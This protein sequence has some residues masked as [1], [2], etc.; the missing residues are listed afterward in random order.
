[1]FKS[2]TYTYTSIV[3]ISGVKWGL[4]QAMLLSYKP[5]GLT[6]LPNLD[7]VVDYVVKFILLVRYNGESILQAWHE[8]E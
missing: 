8:C 2:Y 5:L 7:C 4:E 1:M 6:N 3:I